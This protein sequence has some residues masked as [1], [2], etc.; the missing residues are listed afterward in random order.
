MKNDIKWD[1]PHSF[2]FWLEFGFRSIFDGI[3]M[4]FSSLFNPY[5][6][7]RY[8]STKDKEEKKIK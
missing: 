4:I 8:I 5:V 2:A 3:G 1:E 7:A 6:S